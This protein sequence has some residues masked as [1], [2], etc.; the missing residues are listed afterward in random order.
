MK[1]GLWTHSEETKEGRRVNE[2]EVKQ[3]GSERLT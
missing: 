1:E 2:V 3:R